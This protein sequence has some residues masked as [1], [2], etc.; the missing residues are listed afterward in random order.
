MACADDLQLRL[1]ECIEQAVDL[2]PGQ[3]EHGVDTVR[4]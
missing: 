2:R 4:D 1:L 3:A